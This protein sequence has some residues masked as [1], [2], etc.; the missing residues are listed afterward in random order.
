MKHL[1]T[2]V[3]LLVS[4]AAVAQDYPEYPFPYNPDGNADGYIG[5]S[6]LLDLLVVY[7][8]EYPGSFYGDS[9]GAVLHLGQ[10][11]VFQCFQEAKSAGRH[12][13]VLT[14][15]D[16]MNQMIPV[17]EIGQSLY[18]GIGYSNF[19]FHIQDPF[20]RMYIESIGYTSNESDLVVN[21]LGGEFAPANVYAPTGIDSYNDITYL[22][23]YH[24]IIATEA[25]PEIEYYIVEG[26]RPTVINA[27]SESLS[28]GW[29]IA[30]GV[31]SR[32]SSSIAW[33]AIMRF[34]Q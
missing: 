16:L 6:D 21:S 2:L 24:C 26:D 23:P 32:G 27:V 8:Q 4:T 31:Q 9:T 18:S 22:Y 25:L 1:M 3:A 33:Q 10:M 28:N 34:A 7:G 13:R 20:G 11:P 19:T 15:S 29:R 30:G 17:M 5:L 12:W 14:Y